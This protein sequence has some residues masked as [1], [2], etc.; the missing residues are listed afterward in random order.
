MKKFVYQIIIV[1]ILISLSFTKA[2]V[3]SIMQKGNE[4]YKTINTS[5]QLM[6]TTHL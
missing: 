3:N 6:S 4:L 1:L 2:D 5:L